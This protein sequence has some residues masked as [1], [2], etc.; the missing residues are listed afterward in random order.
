M[1]RVTLQDRRGLPHRFVAPPAA[2]EELSEMQ[3]EREVVRRGVDGRPKA[4][5]QGVGVHNGY[6]GARIP[7]LQSA[8]PR[9]SALEK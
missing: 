6:I 9:L 2:L 7:I 4:L 1:S 3:P 8:P 5:K